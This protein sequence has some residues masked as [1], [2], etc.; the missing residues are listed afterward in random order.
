MFLGMMQNVNMDKAEKEFSKYL[1]F[2]MNQLLFKL[3][4][5]YCVS[6]SE[7]DI[8]KLTWNML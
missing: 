5:K 8:D 7:T 2:Q 3:A 4:S 1:V 6:I